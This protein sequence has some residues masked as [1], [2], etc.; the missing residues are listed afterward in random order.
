M[1]I[2]YQGLDFSR[3]LREAGKRQRAGPTPQA[4]SLYLFTW[5]QVARKV[6]ESAASVFVLAVVEPAVI[7]V[8]DRS[9][10]V[11]DKRMPADACI[12]AAVIDALKV[13][14]C[15]V[16]AAMHGSWWLLLRVAGRWLCLIPQARSRRRRALVM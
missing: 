5:G 11:L 16:P 1:G 12:I 10:D 15:S 6:M 2:R 7:V 13:S 3:E 4:I 14:R 9:N 8:P